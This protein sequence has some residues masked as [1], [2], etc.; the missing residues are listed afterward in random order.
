MRR[1]PDGIPSFSSSWLLVVSG[2]HDLLE[3]IPILPGA[4][5]P[6]RPIKRDFL[7]ATR[8]R[9][10]H[11]LHDSELE[12]HLSPLGLKARQTLSRKINSTTLL[13]EK[14]S[15]DK[16]EFVICKIQ[17]FD[18][19][20][21]YLHAFASK[22]RALKRVFLES[23]CNILVQDV[24]VKAECSTLVQIRPFLPKSLHQKIRYQYSPWKKRPSPVD[25]RHNTHSLSCLGV[26]EAPVQR[27][28]SGSYIRL[29]SPCKKSMPK[30]GI[31]DTSR[32]IQFS[33]R[34]LGKSYYRT[35]HW[36][37]RLPP[38]VPRAEMLILLR[39]R[40]KWRKTL[41]DWGIR[42]RMAMV[43]PC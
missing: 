38:L 20:A 21:E 42:F 12:S 18:C 8:A 6:T 19:S 23:K 27:K 15:H 3:T 35:L 9:M 2:A 39:S 30:G 28:K 33:Y 17:K 22:I 34:R 32:Q 25:H 4:L 43:S 37:S 13:A 5:N 24:H 14:C 36:W 29:L 7:I 41:E 11:I 31:T 1:G 26:L 40:I 16:T 10:V